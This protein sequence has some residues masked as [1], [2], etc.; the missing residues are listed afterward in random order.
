MGF[1]GNFWGILE[2]FFKRIFRGGFL[3]FLGHFSGQN[4]REKTGNSHL[5]T[6]MRK[7]SAWIRIR[8]R[9]AGIWE[10]FGTIPENS[11]I[12]EEFGATP[13][14]SGISDEFGATPGNSCCSLGSFPEF[15]EFWDSL[16]ETLEL[17]GF[18]GI[19]GSRNSRNS[20]KFLRGFFRDGPKS[21]SS[22]SS[23]SRN[24]SNGISA[25]LGISGTNLGFSD[26]NLGFS[27]PGFPKF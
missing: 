10:G 16:D 6:G 9:R 15:P 3:G 2:G 20:W 17:P 26:G 25:G 11:G 1:S 14:N 13:E 21:F 24:S 23:C 4:S 7:T 12:L 27:E 5:D 18:L 19:L 22:Q 8:M